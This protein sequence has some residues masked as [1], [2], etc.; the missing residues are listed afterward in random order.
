VMRQDDSRR[1]KLLGGWGKW[2]AGHWGAALLVALG[3]TAVMAVGVTRLRM[4]MTFHSLLPEGTKQVR[5]LKT[6]E[7]Q[8]PVASSIVAVVAAKQRNPAAEAQRTVVQAVEALSEELSR[9]EYSQ[10]I[11]RVQSKLEQSFFK[12]HGMILSEPEDIAR[13]RRIFAD[14]D[15]VSLFHHV[16]DDFEREYS[17]N[18]EKL[19]DDEEMV[20]AQF[21]GLNRL[22]ANM[23]QAAVGKT[24]SEKELSVSVDRFLFGA[25]YFL[26]KDGTMALLFI[27]P[28]FT[29]DDI[30][31]YV[32]FV[33]RL[34]QTLKR[35]ASGLG[36]EVGLTGLLVVAKDEML[37]SEQGLV[38]SMAIAIVLILVL[39]VLTFRMYSVPLISGIPL[40][41][42]VF[43]T[44]GLAGYIM[45]RLNILSAMY[46]VAL[47]G[48]GIDYAIHLLT[49]YIQEREDGKSFSE[50]IQE[51]MRKSGSGILTGALT[52][53]V[54]FFALIVAESQVVKEL[55]VIAGMGILCELAAMFI[56]VPAL[57]GFRNHILIKRG[58]SSPRLLHGL[59]LRYRF[60]HGLGDR[61]KRLPGLFAILP[62]S[63]AVVFAF[64]APKVQIE[65]NIMNMEAKGLES[66][67]LQDVMVEE[68]GAAPDVMS[69]L[70]SDLEELRRMEEQIEDLAS[71]KRV[72][73][74]L[75]F[76]PSGQE[77]AARLP[78]VEAFRNQLLADRMQT[79]VDAELLLEEM[80]R[81]EDNLLEMS[82]LAYLT[83]MEKMLNRL[84][85]LT[86]RDEEGRKVR[87]THLDG[88]IEQLEGDPAAARRGLLG[89]QK[90]LVPLLGDT[91]FAMAGTDTVTQEML[92]EFILDSYR[93]KDGNA[94]LLNIIP[95]QN[96]WEQEYRTVLTDQLATVSDRATG[97]VLVADQMTQIARIDGVR[98]ALAALITIFIL[99]LIDFRNVKL[100]LLTLLPLALSMISLLGIMAVAGIKFDFINIIA[101]PLLIGIGIDDAVHINHRY[102][103]EGKGQI[104][105]VV[106]KTGRAVLLTSLTTIIGFASFIPS[107]MRAMRS[108]GIVLSIAMALAFL[109]SI[110]FYPSVLVIMAEKLSWA[111]YPWKRRRK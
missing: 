39:L 40:L 48:L 2:S 70:G 110:L 52:T 61:I 84:D 13:M 96:P 6:I 64:Q 72:D 14:L 71:V 66:V 103:L 38:M 36:V 105:R 63:F 92:P 109:F 9:P 65:G 16:N 83:G 54:A 53:A 57:L 97:M 31:S 28:T 100:S 93:A 50:S 17:G 44:M 12:E 102:L 55:G 104:D 101:I 79:D 5:D 10:F 11:V 94:Y 22:L 58:K 25:P 33:P 60:M 106:G 76:Y 47:V 21:E 99:L 87:Q 59:A 107:I 56:L 98:A 82:D 15:L 41:V 32:H 51:S 77:Q 81:L 20:T 80:Y 19:K 69:V 86:G 75:P 85:R 62:L 108:T 42:G 29:V 89:F 68:F 67:E 35:K 46:M 91:L 34:D 43:W 27:Q 26:N 24:V 30:E 18:E 49:T 7:E 3:I 90:T 74:L 73:S 8:F 1:R 88:I 4:E 23:E 37:T 95:T 78:E 45:R 111:L